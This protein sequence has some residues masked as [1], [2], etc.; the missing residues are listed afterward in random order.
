MLAAFTAAFRS[1]GASAFEA[2]ARATGMIN[3]IVQRQAAMLAFLD[4]F[5]LLG[6]VF[7]VVLPILL[8]LKRPKGKVGDVPVH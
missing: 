6:V 4:N 7:L 2:A 3:G 5:K 1:A 8:M